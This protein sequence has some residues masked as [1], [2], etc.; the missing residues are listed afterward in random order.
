MNIPSLKIPAHERYS[1]ELGDKISDLLRMQ[2][3]GASYHLPTPTQLRALAEIE[4]AEAP[5][6]ACIYNLMA[7]SWPC[8]AKRI[9]KPAHSHGT[10]DQRSAD[11]AR[12]TR[13]I[14]Q[15]LEDELPDLRRGVAFFTF[16]QPEL[17]QQ[18]AVSVPF[19]DAAFLRPKPYLRP[20]VRTWDEQGRFVLVD[21]SHGS[22]RFSS[23]RSIARKRCSAPDRRREPAHRGPGACPK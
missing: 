4:S 20:M 17:W 1:P 6:L 21:V 11:V 5:I 8:V 22:S 10:G 9:Q 3:E 19:P 16:T 2:A 23:A 15:T 7:E 13:S 18:I 14:A 12:R